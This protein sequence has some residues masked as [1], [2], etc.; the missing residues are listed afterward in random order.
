MGERGTGNGHKNTAETRQSGGGGRQ[1]RQQASRNY[2]G[3]ARQSGGGGQAGN[4]EPANAERPSFVI[5]HWSLAT[6]NK[7]GGTGDGEWGASTS[8]VGPEHFGPPVA[9]VYPPA[10][11]A[12]WVMGCGRPGLPPVRCGPWPHPTAATGQCQALNGTAF[13]EIRLGD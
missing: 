13:P 5:C 10:W 9:A 4:G 12:G 3:Q 7:Q 11:V 2:G 8:G 6:A 1:A